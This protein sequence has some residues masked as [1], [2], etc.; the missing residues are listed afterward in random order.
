MH[1]KHIVYLPMLGVLCSSRRVWRLV[2]WVLG[3]GCRVPGGRN[4]WQFVFVALVVKGD[5]KALQ[6]VKR[7]FMPV[8]GAA[9][10]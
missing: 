7:V 6:V 1:I 10:V 3:A 4:V 5:D 9:G 8:E 2:R